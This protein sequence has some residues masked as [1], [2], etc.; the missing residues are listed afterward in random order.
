M[1]PPLQPLL[2]TCCW[3]CG[4]D[5]QD[6]AIKGKRRNGAASGEWWGVTE[7]KA[8]GGGGGESSGS[9][10]KQAV[11]CIVTALVSKQVCKRL[12]LDLPQ[13]TFPMP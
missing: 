1:L 7:K 5:F 9:R 4:L 12:T 11:G 6:I 10:R 8:T 13:P 3:H 2:P